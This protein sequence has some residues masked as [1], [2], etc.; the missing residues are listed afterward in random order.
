MVGPIL[1][2]EYHEQML[3]VIEEHKLQNLI[4]FCG[5]VN[6]PYTYIEMSDIMTFASTLEGLP[7]AVVEAM[8]HGRPVVARHLAG[9]TDY[10][11]EHGKTGY[12]F[13]QAT[14]YL[15]YLQQLIDDEIL[16]DRIGRAGK[17]YVLQNHMI[18]Q[19]ASKYV[20]LYRKSD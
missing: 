10:L 6:D 3:Q 11:I 16:R 2:P 17:N 19:I 18:S 4:I 8:G 13:Q 20:D 14:D 5:R 1:E 9:V 15:E 12:L 7:N